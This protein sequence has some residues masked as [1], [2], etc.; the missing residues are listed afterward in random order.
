VEGR[1]VERQH[2]DKAL[3]RGRGRVE[4]FIVPP[5]VRPGYLPE[6]KIKEHK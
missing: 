3:T 2:D 1:C 5:D 6:N 4:S